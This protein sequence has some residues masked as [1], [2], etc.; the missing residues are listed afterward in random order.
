M[1]ILNDDASAGRQRGEK[2]G[3]RELPGPL[4]LASQRGQLTAIRSDAADFLDLTVEE[5]H[6]PLAVDADIDNRTKRGRKVVV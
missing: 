2:R 3:V 5:I 6:G 1:K 4:S